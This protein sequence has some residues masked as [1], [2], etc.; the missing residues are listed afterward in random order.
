MPTSAVAWLTATGVLETAIPASIINSSTLHLFVE[1]KV[2]HTL[3]CAPLDI[4]VVVPGTIMTNI[5]Q[6]L[7]ENSK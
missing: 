2:I 3:V 5:L 7:G 1:D 4:N 6:R